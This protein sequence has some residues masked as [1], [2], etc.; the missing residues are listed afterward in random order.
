M[1]QK[2]NEIFFTVAPYFEVTPQMGLLKNCQNE[3]FGTTLKDFSLGFCPTLTSWHLYIFRKSQTNYG[4]K[5]Q[6]NFFYQSFFQKKSCSLNPV[7]PSRKEVAVYLIRCA[8]IGRNRDVRQKWDLVIT[9]WEVLLT[10]GQRVWTTFCKIFSEMPHLT[11]F[12]TLKYAPKYAKYGQICQIGANWH[13][14]K[15]S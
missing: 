8:H 6:W 11:I 4:P 15:K 14:A 3:T 12:S 10:Q 2:P 5:T 1:G 13:Q 9:D 7:T